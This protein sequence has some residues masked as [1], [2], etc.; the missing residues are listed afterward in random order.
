MHRLDE[1]QVR[2]QLDVLGRCHVEG[3]AICLLNAYV[4]PAHEHR[5]RELVREVLGDVPV[6][7]SSETSPLAKE[8]ARASTTVIDVFMKT[9]FTGYAQELDRDLRELGFEGDL[10]FADCAATLL[11][12]A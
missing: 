4:N 10:N 2:E 3:V 1:A 7:I 6:S 5:L 12:W 9:I 11:P 8:Y